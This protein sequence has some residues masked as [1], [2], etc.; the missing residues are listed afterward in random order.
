M[1]KLRREGEISHIKDFKYRPVINVKQVQNRAEDVNFGGLL[2][3][4]TGGS[5]EHITMNAVA[6]R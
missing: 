6:K 2:P 4:R 3:L 1:P 5:R